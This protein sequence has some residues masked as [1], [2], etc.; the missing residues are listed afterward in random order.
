LR[1]PTTSG[2][3]VGAFHSTLQAI[4]RSAG[5]VL[6]VSPSHQRVTLFDDGVHDDGAMEPDGIYNLPLEDLAKAE[7]TYHFRAVA[8]YGHDCKA[9]RE[10]AWSIHVEPAIDPGRTLVAI[11]DIQD[12]PDGRHGTLVI[13]PRDPFDNPLGPG[14]GDLFTVTPLP[15]VSIDGRL[16]DRGDGSYTV[17]VSWTPPATPGV[18]VQQPDRPPVVVAPPRGQV[19]PGGSRDCTEAA[20]SLLDCIGLDDPKVACVRVTSVNVQI[21]LA[22]MCC[23]EDGARKRGSRSEQRDSAGR[24]KRGGGSCGK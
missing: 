21:D 10:A 13:T 7:G 16:K 5:G 3:A 17:S 22:D 6:P 4:A 11:I 18:V 1:A 8:T 15:G 23:S 9:T 20:Q 12:L 24:G 14:R 19:P 2:D